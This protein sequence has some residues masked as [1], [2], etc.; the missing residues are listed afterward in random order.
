MS[1]PSPDPADP[2][3][4][5]PLAPEPEAT[6]E[7]DAGAA[8]EPDAGAAPVA[9]AL[10]VWTLVA[11]IADDGQE[12]ATNLSEPAGA[13]GLVRRLGALAS[14]APG[15]GRGAAPDRE[16]RLPFR[17]RAQRGPRARRGDGRP[18]PFGLS[19]ASG[20]RRDDPARSRLGPVGPGP[21][22]PG[23]DRPGP[24]SRG[25][26]AKR[27]R[28]RLSGPRDGALVAPRPDDRDGARRRARRREPGPRGPFGCCRVAVGR[29]AGGDQPPPR[30]VRVADAGARAVLSRRCVFDRP[31]PG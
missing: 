17:A 13:R 31:M 21:R 3:P 5:S 4:G 6:P 11:L 15:T 1:L 30:G 18:A 20:R 29:C 22:D 25:R 27:G 14:V 9:S 8:P 10:G 12:P 2:E 16:R 23:T 28:L 26:R 7:P 24:R 19:D